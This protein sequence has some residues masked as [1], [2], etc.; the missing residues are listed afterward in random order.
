MPPKLK[1]SASE[2]SS[3]TAA[4]ST[5]VEGDRGVRGTPWAQTGWTL[6]PAGSST[7]AAAAPSALPSVGYALWPLGLWHPSRSALPAAAPA[8]ARCAFLSP[9]NTADVLCI[10]YHTLG[11]SLV[12]PMFVQE[13]GC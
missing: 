2:P 13:G 6:P 5:A 7:A 12:C 1:L 3:S 11:L 9:V 4:P 8:D 10:N